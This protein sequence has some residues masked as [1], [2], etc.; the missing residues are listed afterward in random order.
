ADRAETALIRAER[1]LAQLLVLA[2]LASARD[3]ALQP[4]DIAAIA[5]TLAAEMVPEAARR[6]VDLGYEGPT[7]AMAD[8]EPVLLQE[9]LR[10]LIDNAVNYAGPGARVT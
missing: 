8:A 9:L 5:R 4:V 3:T 7:T 10:N 2:L 6:T 1:I